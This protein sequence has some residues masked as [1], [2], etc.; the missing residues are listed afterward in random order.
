MK[1]EGGG[2]GCGG[3]G[4]FTVWYASHMIRN[5]VEVKIRRCIM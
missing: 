1:E 2:C 5:K 4:F 3:V